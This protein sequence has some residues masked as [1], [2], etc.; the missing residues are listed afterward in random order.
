MVTH[1]LECSYESLSQV[2]WTFMGLS[3]STYFPSSPGNS[4]P[5][6]FSPCGHLRGAI[7]IWPHSYPGL[8]PGLAPAFKLSQENPPPEGFWIGMFQ[9]LS[10]G[11]SSGI[12]TLSALGFP[13]WGERRKK[14]FRQVGP[15]LR[16]SPRSPWPHDLVTGFFLACHRWTH[17]SSLR[18]GFCHWQANY[19][20]RVFSWPFLA[21]EMLSDSHGSGRR[22]HLWGV[23]V[24]GANVGME[25]SGQRQC[26][27][28]PMS[29]DQHFFL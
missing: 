29:A 1:V 17:S 18:L 15:W 13:Q 25:T 14:T 20:C 3:P 23:L 26:E 27:E 5:T 7:F 16:Y 10:F 24:W 9:S 19:H 11:G 12:W 21:L 2:L 8:A 22:R 4:V 28:R 6:F